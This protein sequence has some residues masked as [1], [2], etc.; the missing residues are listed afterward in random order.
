MRYTRKPVSLNS[1]D[2]KNAALTLMRQTFRSGLPQLVIW[3][4]QNPSPGPS[5]SRFKKSTYCSRTKKLD[6]SI[7][8]PPPLNTVSLIVIVIVGIGPIDALSPL[9]LLRVIEKLSGPCGEY[10]LGMIGIRICFEVS[11]AA[12]FKVP[13]VAM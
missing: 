6:P 8:L 7:G 9:A 3:L 5:G 10:A 11:F 1:I 2:W 13:I 4:V 12:K